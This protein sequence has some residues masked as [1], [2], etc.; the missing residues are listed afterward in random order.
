M[1]GLNS[2]NL[3]LLLFILKYPFSGIILHFFINF[4]PC[5]IFKALI[6]FHLAGKKRC[7]TLSALLN[8]LLS[9]SLSLRNFSVTLLLL[10]FLFSLSLSLSPL[11]HRLILHPLEL[12]K[13][14]HQLAVALICHSLPQTV[15][16]NDQHRH[17][18]HH[19]HLL[20][21]RGRRRCHHHRHL[22]WQ[23]H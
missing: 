11:C 19:H 20:R 12:S 23:V 9:F 21:R 1:Q 22:I 17:V 5:D 18:H 8:F 16:H 3:F 15:V 2:F 7:P 13:R 10:V 6:L 14:Q 4:F